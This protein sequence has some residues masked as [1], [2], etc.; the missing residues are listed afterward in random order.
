MVSSDLKRQSDL[1]QQFM[2]SVCSD[3]YYYYYNYYYNHYYWECLPSFGEESFVLHFVIKKYKD[4]DLQNC[5]FAC[6][7]CMGV[8]L[9]H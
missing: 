2:N 4:E 7:F 9:G 3:Y 5:N 8:R 1:P 6:L